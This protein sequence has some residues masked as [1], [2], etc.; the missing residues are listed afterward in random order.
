MRLIISAI[1]RSKTAKKNKAAKKNK[2]VLAF[3]I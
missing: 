3:Y 2:K 1:K